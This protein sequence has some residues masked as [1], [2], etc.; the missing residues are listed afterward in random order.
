MERTI[1]ISEELFLALQHL[2]EHRQE[3]TDS[4]AESWLKQLLNLDN[5]PDLEWAR[6]W[7]VGALV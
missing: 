1:T 5:Y 6:R 3:S 4:L 7:V 2:A